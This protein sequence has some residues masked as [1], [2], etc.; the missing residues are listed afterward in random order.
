M[1]KVYFYRVGVDS[2]AGGFWG[3]I[4]GN[5]HY[6]PIP[7][8]EGSTT[9]QRYRYSDLPC[10]RFVPIDMLEQV[11]HLDPFFPSLV[12]EHSSDPPSFGEPYEGQYIGNAVRARKLAD[13]SCGD[14]LFFWAG[15]RPKRCWYRQQLTTNQLRYSQSDC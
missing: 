11:P 7:E 5:C 3:P 15:L 10:S 8:P 4:E 6:I 12:N 9:L 1:V 2:G 13:L 14:I